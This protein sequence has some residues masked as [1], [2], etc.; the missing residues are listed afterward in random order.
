MDAPSSTN[1]NKGNQNIALSNAD[2]WPYKP[3]EKKLVDLIHTEL[4]FNLNWELQQLNGEA[5]I[6]MKPHF[7]SIKEVTLDAHGMEIQKVGTLDTNGRVIPLQF[8]SDSLT[9]VVTLKEKQT[10]EDTFN[11]YVKYV[12]KPNDLVTVSDKPYKEDKG[13]YFINPLNKIKNK[14]Q[15]AWTQGEPEANS[16]WFPTIDAPNQKMTQDVFI[17]VD[18]RFET[19]SN[20]VKLREEINGDGTKTVHWQQL[21]PHAPYLCNFV[22]GEYAIIKDQWED[23]PVHYYVEPKDSNY[24]RL[25]FGNTPEMIGFYSELFG[26]RYP[27]AKYHQAVIRDFV[28]GAMENTSSVVHAN[29]VFRDS[30]QYLDYDFE[31]I[32]AHE[33]MHHWFG[34]LVTCESWANLTLNEGFATYGEYLWLDEKYGSIRSEQHLYNDKRAYF[35]DAPFKDLIRYHHDRPIDMFD[36]HSYAK[37]G[38]VLHMLRN[39]LGDEAFFEGIKYYLHEN[40]YQPVEVHHLRLAF[41]KI[42]GE[43]LNW[44]FNQWYLAEGHPV[45]NFQT[46]QLSDSLIIT[47]EQTQN[48]QEGKPFVLPLKMNIY[49]D[50][51]V[52]EKEVWLTS[53]L[54]TFL[55]EGMGN[56]THVVPNPDY[57]QLIDIQQKI[58]PEQA[59]EQYANEK[60]FESKIGALRAV[61][62]DTSL[63]TLELFRAAAKDEHPY[64]RRM[65][66]SF[67]GKLPRE[68]QSDEI[69]EKLVKII[70]KDSVAKVRGTALHVLQNSFPEDTL[71]IDIYK[72]SLEDPSNMVKAKALSNLF[73]IKRED[74]LLRA[75]QLEEN[76]DPTVIYLLTKKYKEID[77][78][79]KVNYFEFAINHT[80]GVTK[81]MVIENFESY[82]G[83]KGSKTIKFGLTKLKYIALNENDKAARERAGLAIQ[84]MHEIHLKRIEDIEKDIADRKSSTKGN[85]YDLK[86]LE[87]KLADLQQK[88][89]EIQRIINDLLNNEKNSSIIQKWKEA[90]ME[91]KEV[92]EEA[93]DAEE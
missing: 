53:R 92:E 12:S 28:A 85:S 54:D 56:V 83:N 41:E 43:D 32:V 39:Y 63:T 27:W 29:F 13:L 73:E 82:L 84:K 1:N 38:L 37:G 16:I 10:R 30:T 72:Q 2:E 9:L 87:E 42:S 3:S 80:E 23:I 60:H 35:G 18:E 8:E 20:G 22:V 14:P 91:I 57:S 64:V 19:L 51:Q 76:T 31:D 79:S 44:F 15:Q 36:D 55:F 67:W 6:Q 62:G 78:E 68:G 25:N 66:I 34:D 71:L 77:D 46:Q 74:A 49:E 89:R 88:E 4:K 81:L 5:V 26:F 70:R 58:S 47:V 52:V 90:G 17:T 69:K 59:E 93:A 75:V 21:K 40:A 48:F 61:N 65:A 7:H 24:A 86:M 33:L 50:G 11:I 45:V